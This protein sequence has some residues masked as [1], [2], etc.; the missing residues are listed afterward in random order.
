MANTFNPSTSIKYAI[1]SPLHRN[2]SEASRQNISLV[3]YDVLG[4][5][6]AVLVNEEKP[7]GE[8]EIKFNGGSLASG[9]YV[10]RLKTN[11]KI[12]SKKMILLK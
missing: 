4:N 7:A 8:Y 11:R 2:E 9:I 10:Y 1:G 3:V 5:E 6:V 12:I